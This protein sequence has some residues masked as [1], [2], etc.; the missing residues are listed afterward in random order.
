M[1]VSYGLAATL[2][3]IDIQ[4]LYAYRYAVFVERLGWQL[5]GAVNG[6]EIDQF[7][8]SDTIHVMARNDEGQICGCARL[9]PTVR[10]YL[11][12]EVFPQLM[13][14]ESLPASDDVWEL[15]RFSS[16]DLNQNLASPIWVCRE[17]MAAT[18]SCAITVGAKRLIAVTSRGVDRILGRL[19]INWQPVG[20]SMK[21]G[22]Q[23]IF[24]FWVE[25]DEKTIEALGLCN[26]F[27]EV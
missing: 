14:G 16:A 21:I 26:L 2:R 25:I 19:G 18:V 20:P 5:P 27:S 7:D 17:V 15:S 3:K 4:H 23:A 1:Q 8:R 10:P 22:G 11:L 6:L 13:Y 24:A 9:L 12:R